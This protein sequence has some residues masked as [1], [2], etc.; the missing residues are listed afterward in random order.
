MTSIAGFVDSLNNYQETKRKLDLC[1]QT[2]T[3]DIEYSCSDYR[4]TFESAG[5]DLANALN[6]YVDQRVAEEVARLTAVTPYAI[7]DALS[8]SR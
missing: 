4:R 8:A 2:A 6:G 7:R 3:G 5:Q 1:R